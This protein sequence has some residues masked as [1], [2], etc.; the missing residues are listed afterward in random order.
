M[1]KQPTSLASQED[2]EDMPI[3]S[4]FTDDA[5]SETENDLEPLRIV[6]EPSTAHPLNC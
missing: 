3:E 5:P 4:G 2:A 1:D 6:R